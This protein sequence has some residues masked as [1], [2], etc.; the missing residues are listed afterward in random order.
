VNL[1]CI[2]SEYAHPIEYIVGNLLPVYAGSL[3]LGKNLHCI[4]FALWTIVRISESHDTHSGYEFTWSPFR[5]IPFQTTTSYHEYHH[6]RNIGNYSTFFTIWDTVFGSNV[7]FY[8]F[9]KNKDKQL[10]NVES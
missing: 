7:E 1:V 3:I 10:M 6:S 9:L 4:S 8:K 2:S 5:L